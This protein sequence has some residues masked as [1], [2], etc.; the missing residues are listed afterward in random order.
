[1]IDNDKK[2]EDGVDDP[3]FSYYSSLQNQA[4]MLS[5]TIRTTSYRKAILGNAIPSF[6]DKV[7]MDVGAG[8]G[9]LSFFA[10]E[11][12]AKKVY[13]MEASDMADKMQIVREPLSRSAR[14]YAPYLV[15]RFP[16]VSGLLTRTSAQSHVLADRRRCQPRS[17]QSAPCEQD[18]DRQ[19]KDRRLYRRARRHPNQ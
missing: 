1:M 5:D 17:L 8:S 2:P 18:S 13:S 12:G 19:G 16:Y 11:A 4:N 7:V 3:Y 15:N 9:V 14:L 6:I 10:V